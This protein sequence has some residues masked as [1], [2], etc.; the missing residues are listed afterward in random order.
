MIKTNCYFV[1][2]GSQYISMYFFFRRID[3]WWR[4]D[5]PKEYTPPLSLKDQS[6]I[7]YIKNQG[8]YENVSIM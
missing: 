2:K 1:E 6:L 3:A 4:R 7:N 8:W 5:S